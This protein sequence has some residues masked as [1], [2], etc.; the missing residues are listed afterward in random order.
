MTQRVKQTGDAP[1][2]RAI[3]ARFAID[4]A[5]GTIE[6]LGRG[7][8]NDTFSL[9]AGGRRYVLQRINGAVFP[10]PERIMANLRVLGEH[11]AGQVETGL[12]LPEL[13]A[14][15]DG[16]SSL[17]DADGDCWRL[18]EFIPDAVTLERITHDAQ[19][20]EVGAAL[21]RFHRLTESLPC[22]RLGFSLP[23]F[24]ATP[25]YL[26]R[27]LT[28]AEQAGT[29][30]QDPDIS[31]AL[32]F[33]A[34]RHGLASVLD[35]ALRDGRL[36]LRVTHG[37]PKLDNILF[38]ADD[39]RAIALIDLDTVQPGLIQHDLGDCLRSCCNRGGERADGGSAVRF[40]LTL[41][42]AILDGYAQ[43]MRGLL[44][45]ADIVLLYDAIRL[46]PFELGLRFLTD[47]LA[48]DRYFRVSE[49]GENLRKAGIQFALV[50]DIER[51]EAAIR[52]QIAAK[53][54]HLNRKGA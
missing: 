51:Q 4:C 41:C 36:R 35:E 42:A 22:E 25:V 12:R 40:D 49:R 18:M 19:A 28:L 27:L 32:D 16:A 38:A 34:T 26:E 15:R 13:I 31:A 6:P 52:A 21:G 45:P 46:L 53:F 9:E 5:P 48:G 8:I 14:T 23:D 7:L 50:A 39:G 43:E 33:V 17:R 11:L 3:A 20:R 30:L 1:F 29:A 2:L 10:D 47:H 24:H 44:N 37:D 54:G